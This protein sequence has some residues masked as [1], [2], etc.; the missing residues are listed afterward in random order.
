MRIVEISNGDVVGEMIV[1]SHAII[2]NIVLVV[3]AFD[4]TTD[5]HFSAAY[6]YDGEGDLESLA[7]FKANAGDFDQLRAADFA[8]LSEANKSFLALVLEYMGSE[9]EID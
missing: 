7:Q 4:S 1:T 9:V 3:S 6:R 5:S 2:A 8:T